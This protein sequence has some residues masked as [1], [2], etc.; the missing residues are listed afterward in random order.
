MTDRV[1]CQNTWPSPPPVGATWQYVEMLMHT[2]CAGQYQPIERDR[3]VVKVHS[4]QGV[5]ESLYD[6]AGMSSAQSWTAT[7]DGH[8]VDWNPDPNAYHKEEYA[9]DE[10]PIYAERWEHGTRTFAGYIHS[11]SRCVVATLT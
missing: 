11:V 5:E 6:G 9:L 10:Y 8:R 7:Q 1:Q 3:P 4:R 2:P